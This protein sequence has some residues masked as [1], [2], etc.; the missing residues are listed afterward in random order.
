[1]ILLDHY[2]TGPE[3][4]RDL[5]YPT[6]LSPAIENNAVLTVN[7]GNA[8][9]ERAMAMGCKFQYTI[10]PRTG[11]PLAS[12]WRPPVVNASTPNAAPNS[13][14]MTGQ[15]ED[16]FDPRQL[17]GTWAMTKDGQDALK[18]IGLWMEDIIRTPTW[19]HVQTVQPG[20][21]RR[22]FLP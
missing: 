3:G 2:W 18:E 21:G 19:L 12:G 7:L 20:S 6:A 17:L 5:L 4:R 10:S 14:H 22:V 8:F 1:M 13:K 15:A 9:C 11:T 16:I